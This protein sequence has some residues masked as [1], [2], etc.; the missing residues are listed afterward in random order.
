MPTDARQRLRAPARVATTGQAKDKDVGPPP[1][2][3]PREDD[4]AMNNCGPMLATLGLVATTL[5]GAD[6]ALA[7][8]AGKWPLRWQIPLESEH[9]GKSMSEVFNQSGFFRA[10]SLRNSDN[11]R[12]FADAPGG[13]T[14]IRMDVRKGE[15]R[16]VSFHLAPLGKPG[17]EQACLTLDL[18]LSS[19]F[20][21]GTAGTKLGFG[22]WGG[23]TSSNNSGGIP[24]QLQ[25][26]WSVRDVNNAS[27]IRAYSYHLNR[28]GGTG[29]KA[30]C[31]PYKCLFGESI[32]SRVRLQPGQWNKV[33][34]EVE[35][36]TIGS[37]NGSLKMWVNG[38]QV[39]SKTGLQWRK[40]ASWAIQG[41]KFTDMWGGVTSDPKNFSPKPQEIFYRDYRLYAPQGA[42]G[43]L[44]SDD[45]P[46]TDS[47]AT[48]S[49]GADNPAGG[50]DPSPPA[51]GGGETDIS[52][53]FAPIHP[54][55]GTTVAPL[56]Q[57]VWSGHPQA[58]RYYIRLVGP[59]NVASLQKTYRLSEVSC[60][61]SGACKVPY[62]GTALRDGRHRLVLRAVQSGAI[63]QEHKIDFTVAANGGGFSGGADAGGGDT[64]TGDTGTGDTG[65][66]GEPTGGGGGP[67]T[68][69]APV[70][71]ISD[72]VPT[73]VWTADAVDR[74]YLR[75]VDS[76]GN[77]VFTEKLS[78]A[79]AQCAGDGVCEYASASLA[80]GKYRWWVRG[81]YNGVK[82]PDSKASFEIR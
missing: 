39:T 78:P 2:K 37:T 7:G 33:E 80:A 8:C 3:V 44:A 63:L 1:D 51:T 81:I 43:T 55:A 70:G 24:P 50:S 4:W 19:D 42:G 75:A 57:I 59:S 35:M 10:G 65:T 56:S 58:D 66:G 53:G 26:G 28:V 61:S 21:W 23:D 46:A 38:T 64:S 25:E 17:A 36:N 20:D 32:G 5:A 54:A 29:T 52:D 79:A 22:L 16:I 30:A 9:V 76:G 71:T 45:P 73:F 62:S 12:S 41:L 49:P 69:Q 11:R 67:V 48:D 34:M 40:K 15:N 68:A 74:Y 13:G 14:A 77:T 18:Y 82:G 60:D 31:Q 6:D 47:P 72:N 27:G